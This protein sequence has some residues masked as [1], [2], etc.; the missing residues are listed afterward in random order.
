MASRTITDSASEILS[1]STIRK[2]FAIQNE[3]ASIAVYLKREGN[4]SLTV[5]AT[6]HDHRLSAGASIALNRDTDGIEATQDRWTI[7]AASGTPR[8]SYFETEDFRR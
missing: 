8:V 7:I 4:N 6:D 2:S 5:S 3:D 1:R